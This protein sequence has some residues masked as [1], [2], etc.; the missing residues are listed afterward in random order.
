MRVSEMKDSPT[1]SVSN[2]DA[3]R[4]DSALQLVQ[5]MWK[6]MFSELGLP[7]YS[8]STGIKDGHVLKDEFLI[9]HD[10]PKQV[11]FREEEGNIEKIVRKNLCQDKDDCGPNEKSGYKSWPALPKMEIFANE[12]FQRNTGEGPLEHRPRVG[13]ISRIHSHEEELRQNDHRIRSFIDKGNFE[14]L[15]F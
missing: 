10:N 13:I 14:T 12:S 4:M 5:E 3:Q 1:P 15:K 2:E 9:K 7:R 8:H 11:D 6:D